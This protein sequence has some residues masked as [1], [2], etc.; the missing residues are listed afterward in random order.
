[1]PISLLSAVTPYLLPIATFFGFARNTNKS[2]ATSK[3]IALR[4]SDTQKELEVQRH[5]TQLKLAYLNIESQVQLEKRRQEFQ[6]ESQE[7]QQQ[8]Q[9]DLTYLNIEAQ[10]QLAK[11]R[12][13]FELGLQE[14]QQQFQERMEYLR[15]GQQ[16]TLE[17]ARQEFQVR[18]NALQ[19]EQQ[20][21]IQTF[22]QNVQLAINQKNLDFQRWRFEQETVLQQQLA[23]YNRQT[24][25]LVA[26]YQRETALKLPE[27][28]KL[29]ENWP[30]RIVPAQILNSHHEENVIPLRIIISPPSVEFDKFEHTDKQNFP[31]IE[32]RL[33]EGLR[34]LLNQHYPLQSPVRPT[35]LLDGA[36]D[37]GRFHGGASIKGLFS[38]LQSEPTLVLESEVDSDYLNFRLAYWSVGQG[39]YQYDSL[40]SK[41]PYR[42]ILFASAKQRALQWKT[43]VRDKLV[44]KGMS[45]K[46]IDE[47]Y[48][49]TQLHGA[50]NA[51]NLVILEEEEEFAKL[52]IPIARQYRLEPK[53]WEVLC[54]VLE[55]YHCIVTGVMAD[56]HHL[57]HNNTPLLFPKVLP[58]WLKNEALLPTES[59][60]QWV[61]SS[62]QEV[63]NM[64]A[65]ERAY[66]IP[67]WTLQLA[68]GLVKFGDKR[69]AW[70]LVKDSLSLHLRQSGI[71][72]PDKEANIEVFLTA[73]KPTLSATNRNY[74]K[75]IGDCLA[76]LH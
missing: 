4:Q 55:T 20:K 25:L 34:Q 61:V 33:A 56:I 14:R 15:F 76:M 58:Q 10:A 38:L 16:V 8:F 48:D 28:N 60:L 45:L 68:E 73:M 50:Y 67:E 11:R 31:K 70:E 17:K 54:Q 13:E 3:E 40:I 30:L 59:I 75:H 69:W 49:H 2:T 64:L 29:F 6:L 46:E 18:F 12:Q 7:R 42:D 36:W 63:F 52:G 53:D 74:V 9:K 62:Y 71:A 1:M 5:Q 44:A 47:R 32:K 37:S 39:N 23:E 72:P 65:M 19:F 41:L 21:E 27:A 66:Q 57:I 22:I 26:H 43:E 35:E 51:T 24:Q